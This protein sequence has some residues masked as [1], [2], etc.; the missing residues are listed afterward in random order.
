LWGNG[1]PVREF[2]CSDDLAEAIYKVLKSTKKKLFKICNNNFPILNVGSG[3]IYSIKELAELIKNKTEFRGKILF[4]KNFP[5]GVM[6]KNLSSSRIKKLGWKPLVKLK[7]G[8]DDILKN[9][10]F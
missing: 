5:N 3:D 7:D 8:V 1:R 9:L 6:N 2:L 4:N 10:K